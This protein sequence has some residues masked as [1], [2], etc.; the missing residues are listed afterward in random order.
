MEDD[1]Y[2]WTRENALDDW[3]RAMRHAIV[4]LKT[5]STKIRLQF[6]REDLAPLVKT[7]GRYG[8]LRF[9]P[10]CFIIDSPRPL[11]ITDAR[12]L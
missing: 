1:S 3:P 11:L 12:H 2:Q 8:P 4:M 6:L 7:A 9:H 10:S 5:T